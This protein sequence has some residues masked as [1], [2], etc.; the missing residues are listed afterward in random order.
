MVGSR[1][2]GVP[3]VL[4]EF[5]SLDWYY[6]TERGWIALV[7]CDQERTR[8]KP[9]LVGSDVVIDG[10]TYRCTGVERHMPATPISRGERIGLLVRGE[11]NVKTEDPE[12]NTAMYDGINTSD[13]ACAVACTLVSNPCGDLLPVGWQKR[14]NDLI[15]ALRDER[16]NLRQKLHLRPG[17]VGHSR[18]N[19]IAGEAGWRGLR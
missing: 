6:V 2:K 16:N 15:R 19:A 13:E 10:E 7:E 17:V 8:D 9:G 1:N 14:V 3:D 11:P 4:P 5:K 18:V 12:G